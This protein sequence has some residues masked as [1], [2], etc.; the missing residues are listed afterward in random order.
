MEVQKAMK[1]QLNLIVDVLK[2]RGSGTTNDGNTA[3]TAFRNHETFAKIL[4][5]DEDLVYRFFVIL[6]TL[7][8]KE[9]V[10]PDKFQEY[11]K[12]TAYVG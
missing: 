9:P 6:C 2:T 10:N 7:S 3:R 5:L 12:E 4:G 8:R 11:N 1:E